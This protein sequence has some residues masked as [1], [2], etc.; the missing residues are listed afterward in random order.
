MV[1]RE[2]KVRKMEKNGITVEKQNEKTGKTLEN[3]REKLVV[4][5]IKNAEN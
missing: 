1:T 5:R 4:I 3:T 2:K